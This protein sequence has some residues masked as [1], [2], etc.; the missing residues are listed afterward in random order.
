MFD[1]WKKETIDHER[2]R[3][4]KRKRERERNLPDDIT[5]LL[6]M[7]AKYNPLPFFFN[8]P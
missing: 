3:E 8:K 6:D 7:M 1:N 4:K 2:E 5:L